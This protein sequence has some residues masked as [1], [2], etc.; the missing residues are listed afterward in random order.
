[1]PSSTLLVHLPYVKFLQLRINPIGGLANVIFP[2]D[3]FVTTLRF[4]LASLK[5]VVEH[6]IELVDIIDGWKSIG[7]FYIYD[8][9]STYKKIIRNFQ[10]CMTF[11]LIFLIFS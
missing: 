3:I 6:G 10:F 7:L 2:E 8:N 1:M 5:A 4:D 9:C 11:Y